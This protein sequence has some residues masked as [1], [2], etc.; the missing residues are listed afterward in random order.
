M[1][2]VNRAPTV[3]PI[4]IFLVARYLPLALLTPL[5]ALC[6]E[7]VAQPQNES[8]EIQVNN[9]RPGVLVKQNKH[10]NPFSESNS[11]HHSDEQLLEAEISEEG[12]SETIEVMEPLVLSQ[13]NDSTSESKDDQEEEDSWRVY[14]DLYAFLPP[15]TKSTSTIEGNTTKVDLPLSDVIKSIDEA[16][17]LK[18]QFEYG[19]V[20]VLAAINYATLSASTSKSSFLETQNPLKNK[21]GIT[22]PLR[23]RTIRIQ[24]D[25]DVDVDANQ[26][27][28]DL[29]MRY[30]A[31]AIQKPRMK[32]GSTSFLG[33]VGARFIDANLSTDFNIKTKTDVTVE[34]VK[35]SK[36][37]SRELERSSNASWGNTWV[38]P[39]VGMFG[40]YAISEDWQAFAYLD[41]GGFGLSGS[42]DLSGTAQAGIA[43]ALGNSAQVSLSYK[44]FG[45]AYFEGGSENNGY[46]SYQSGVN[47]GLRW[48][49]D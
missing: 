14:L 6:V 21:L 44:Y 45:I 39:M 4:S 49:F 32:K 46:S 16:L 25:L 28:F 33:L 13:S 29:A 35:V 37:N 10:Y 20:G 34:G 3:R 30:R 8:I 18:A 41:A 43:Y 5:S 42:Q 27:I 1:Q 22:S 2:D 48:L 9:T 11:A 24:G 26:T 17:T 47:L 36:S 15:I 19:R 7:A 31:G 12:A 23:T 40:T 38:Q